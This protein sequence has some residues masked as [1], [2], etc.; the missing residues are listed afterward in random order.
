MKRLLLILALFACA[1]GLRAEDDLFLSHDSLYGQLIAGDDYYL[2]SQPEY[3]AQYVTSAY[4]KTVSS[5]TALVGN[6]GGTS[7]CNTCSGSQDSGNANLAFVSYFVT[8][9]NTSSVA[10]LNVWVPAALT[11]ATWGL[12]I[13]AD[14]SGSGTISCVAT[15]CT[16]ISGSS[17]VSQWAGDPI[18]I[19]GYNGTIY[20]IS[21]G[22]GTAITLTGS[23][24]TTGTVAFQVTTPGALVCYQNTTGTQA[25]GLNTLTPSCSLSSSTAY[26]VTQ[27]SNYGGGSN[28]EATSSI[29]SYCPQGSAKLI[30][31]GYATFPTG[32]SPW[33]TSWPSTFPV[34]SNANGQAGSA[35]NGCYGAFAKIN[36]TS[37]ATYNVLTAAVGNADVPGTGALNIPA[38][39]TGDSLW[40][41]V[42]VAYV[43]TITSVEDCTGTT[44][45]CSSSTD[46]VVNVGCSAVSGKMR[47]CLYYIDRPTAG[48]NNISVAASSATKLMI[49]TMEVQGT[50]ATSSSDQS[51]FDSTTTSSTTPYSGCTTSTTA[52]AVEYW[53]GVSTNLSGAANYTQGSFTPTGS[54][55]LLYNGGLPGGSNAQSFAIFNQV[56][57]S[58]G[59][60]QVTGDAS[61][62]TATV[63]IQTF[64]GTFK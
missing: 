35:A 52:Q 10:S 36:Y 32:G 37:S 63:A 12:G 26:W 18:L 1:G 41:V 38:V 50:A 25:F 44:T 46:T 11:S 54:W 7:Y 23:A 4:Q 62:G 24:G 39:Q 43:A 60:C 51:C 15:A 5:G 59:T 31:S 3:D 45:S 13:Y 6:Y 34:I 29:S 56:T 8:P 42:D 33:T 19:G 16:I 53:I 14:A 20:T 27:V 30:T 21:T 9:A 47:A 40:I 64:C 17:Y 2:V 58:T 48:V 55:N 22:S 28:M 57:S 61:L 49:Y